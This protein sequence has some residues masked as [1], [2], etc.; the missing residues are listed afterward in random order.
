MGTGGVDI[1]KFLRQVMEELKPMSDRM[2]GTL[3]MV[4]AC[5]LI[6]IIVLTFRNPMGDLGVFL[7][8]IFLQR[9]RP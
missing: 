4:C 2:G 7:V 8:F 1:P 6:W 9:K 5:L 3:R